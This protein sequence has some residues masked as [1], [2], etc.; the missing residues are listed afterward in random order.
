MQIFI[1]TPQ[2]R[3]GFS[4]GFWPVSDFKT[5]FPKPK[6]Q[7]KSETSDGIRNYVRNSF[8]R[9]KGLNYSHVHVGSDWE[10]SQTEIL[11]KLFASRK[12]DNT[13]FYPL[14]IHFHHY[15]QVSPTT[16]VLAIR[17]NNP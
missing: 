6:P 8:I 10:Y 7:S 5:P 9:P 16:L 13:N 12:T 11:Q 2:F 3:P 14:S 4:F 15:I 17:V 1:R